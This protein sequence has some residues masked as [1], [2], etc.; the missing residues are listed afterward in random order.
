VIP[1]MIIIGTYLIEKIFGNK[2]L[3]RLSKPSFILN[4]IILS[5]TITSLVHQKVL[6][7]PTIFFFGE[8]ALFWGVTYLIRKFGN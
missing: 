1:I 4:F 8:L 7:H 5:I 6:Y 2:G 3:K